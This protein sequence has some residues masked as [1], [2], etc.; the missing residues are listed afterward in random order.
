MRNL[1]KFAF[2]MLALGVLAQVSQAALI[3]GCPIPAEC[4]GNEYAVFEV[5]HASNTYVLQVNVKVTNSYTGNQFTDNVVAIALSGLPAFTNGALLSVPGGNWSF[6]TDEL[7]ANGCAGGGTNSLCAEADS[8]A[9][10]ANLN[11]AGTILSWQFSFDSTAASVS[12]VH[13]KYLYASGYDD[14]KGWIKEG[15]LGSFDIPVQDGPDGDD[16]GVPEPSTYAM[17]GIAGVALG[18]WKR[19]AA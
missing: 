19:K 12:K 2:A 6:F 1:I 4:N 13:L 14:K 7:N 9:D 5:S 11:S 16:P 3:Y 17:I 10:G 15:S 8:F 18:L